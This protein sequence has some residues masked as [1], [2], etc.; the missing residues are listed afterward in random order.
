MSS[1]A[2]PQPLTGPEGRPTSVVR[3]GDTVLR[4]A[5]PWT[6]AVHALLGHLEHVG[7]TGSP[8]VVGTGYDGHGHEVVS[9]IPGDFTHPHA[10]SEEGGRL[11]RL[12][13][14]RPD[15]PPR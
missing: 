3:R 8:R 13:D 14:V 10:W 4:P 15:R 5:G 9:Y 1:R 12:A 7:F 6:P 2:S 11:H